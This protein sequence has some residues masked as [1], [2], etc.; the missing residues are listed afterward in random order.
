[1]EMGLHA[2]VSAS[3]KACFGGLARIAVRPKRPSVL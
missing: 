1:M 3:E 2:G